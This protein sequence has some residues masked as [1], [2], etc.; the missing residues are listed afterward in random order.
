MPKSRGGRDLV[1]PYGPSA[2]KMPNKEFQILMENAEVLWLNFEG[3]PGDYNEAGQR[4]FCVILDPEVAEDMA[5]DG[6]NVKQTKG[7]G[8][9]EG[10]FYI[11]VDVKYR[12]R[13]GNDLRPPK[14]QLLTSTGPVHLMEE[15]AHFLDKV[16]IA[17]VDLIINGRVRMEDGQRKIKGYLQTYFCTVNEDYLEQKYAD[18]LAG[19]DT[20]S[21]EEFLATQAA[22]A[23]LEGPNADREEDA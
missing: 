11:S 17:K 3:R 5:A 10:D 2:I 13:F 9:E 22:I 16:E 14:L 7:Y 19:G 12:D 4:N 23:E 20:E 21:R 15:N 18:V 8:D 6:W 1:K